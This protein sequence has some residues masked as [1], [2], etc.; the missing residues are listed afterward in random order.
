MPVPSDNIRDHIWNVATARLN[1]AADSIKRPIPNEAALVQQVPLEER[2]AMLT[3]ETL[4]LRMQTSTK[5]VREIPGAFESVLNA[6]WSHVLSGQAGVPLVMR[7]V[8]GLPENVWSYDEVNYSPW[9]LEV[10]RQAPRNGKLEIMVVSSEAGCP[11]TR[12]NVPRQQGC[13]N[14]GKKFDITQN[15]HFYIRH[16]VMRVWYIVEIA[17][18][19]WYVVRARACPMTSIVVGTPGIGKSFGCGSFLLHQ[20]L[21]CEGGL[22]DVVAYFVGGIAYVIH[23]A[24]AGVPGRVVKYSEQSA[25]V[26]VI[27]N[28]TTFNEEASEDGIKMG[29]VIVDIG[30]GIKAPPSGT[31]TDLWPTVVL[32]SPDEKHYADWEKGTNGP[33]IVV[34]CD[35]A[36]DLMAF[37]AWKAM[38]GLAKKSKL[39]AQQWVEA[40]R[41]LEE[42]WTEVDVRTAIVGPLPRFVFMRESYDKLL[43]R[44]ARAVS[45]IDS[46]SKTKYDVLS[47]D[48]GVWQ[49]NTDAHAIEVCAEK[50]DWQGM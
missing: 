42:Q 38:Y 28:M 21:H 48:E 4:N 31:R 22:L 46:T 35:D 49:N 17:L 6:R 39:N 18:R 41:W 47:G 50:G 20:L 44:I 2:A 12:L 32:T 19:D 5:L 14:D 37:V 27:Q 45:A 9:P 16:E 7:V 1:K 29:F 26:A 36:R 33:D 34:N 43:E 23:N 15:K 11:Y 3:E 40:E 10:D 25:A 30:K 24:R 13:V 8:D